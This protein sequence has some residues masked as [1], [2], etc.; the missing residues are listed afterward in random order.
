MQP[1][2]DTFYVT[3][4]LARPGSAIVI[5]DL[6]GCVDPETGIA[7]DW[8]SEI[9]RHEGCYWEYSVSGT[10]LRLV[11]ARDPDRP[12]ESSGER[13]GVGLF[14]NGGRGA[15][16]QLTGDTSVEVTTAR[17]L[18]DAL[19]ARKG[20][21]R[22]SEGQTST[23]W[24]E[25]PQELV[26][27][28]VRSTPNDGRIRYDDYVRLGLALKTIAGDDAR[29]LFIWWA[30]QFPEKATDVPPEQKW[31][32]GF[33]RPTGELGFG[34]LVELCKQ[35]NGGT[36]PPAI[37][38]KLRSNRQRQLVAMMPPPPSG[39]Q[40]PPGAVPLTDDKLLTQPSDRAREMAEFL[41]VR[42]AGLVP[43]TPPIDA[44]RIDAMINGVVWSG[45][46]AK[47]NILNNEGS[48]IV[49]GRSDGWSHICRRYGNPLDV[50]GLEG[51]IDKF[52]LPAAEAKILLKAVKEAVRGTIESDLLHLNQRERLEW[53][54]DPFATESRVE[55]GDVTAR[56]ILTHKK[57]PTG[58]I[59][60]KVI[61]DFREHFPEFDKLLEWIVACRFAD[62]RKK[63]YLWMRASSDFGK[64]LIFTLMKD[65]GAVVE[66]SIKEVEAAF[67]GKPLAKGPED[68][69]RALVLWVDEFKT[70]KS[71]LKQLQNDITLAP[72][73]GMS[74]T[75]QLF[76]KIFTS[77]ET[78][79]SLAGD[80]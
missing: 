55:L 41:D 16:L 35:G 24:G 20:S 61:D 62:D 9:L 26:W 59:D 58:P 10:G 57:F 42:I 5:G 33:D 67:E 37:D 27:E 12:V 25:V 7:S 77:A 64:G 76:A 36:L 43:D 65:L 39:D 3:G 73:F 75:V 6:D 4:Y 40:L 23:D 48:L 22:Q 15:V 68:F 71:E 29:E 53:R 28:V 50:A 47:W 60:D 52:A 30:K 56:F 17:P 2:P 38:E 80:H 70:V 49:F 21:Q 8:A 45:N 44:R 13:N 78:V 1:A 32:R 14:E 63:S 34:T 31:D 18:V 11:M 54:V 46:K 74:S 79:A 19:L 69:R 51:A 66:M 72:K